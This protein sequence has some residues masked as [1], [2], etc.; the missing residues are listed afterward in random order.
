ME[1]LDVQSTMQL[2]ITFYDIVIKEIYYLEIYYYYDTARTVFT[3]VIKHNIYFDKNVE[4]SLKK[5]CF[6]FTFK[7]SNCIC[8]F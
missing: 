5:M 8:C 6:A 3:F 7:K 1:R 4:K 2:T